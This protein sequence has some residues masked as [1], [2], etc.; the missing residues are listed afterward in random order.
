M[1]NYQASGILLNIPDTGYF[2]SFIKELRLKKLKIMVSFNLGILKIGFIALLVPLFLTCE[3]D[4]DDG[5]AEDPMETLGPLNATFEML[6]PNGTSYGTFGSFTEAT[7]STN[8]I[9]L[10][11]SDTS[12]LSWVEFNSLNITGTGQYTL[13][14]TPF[15]RARF[16][17]V[18]ST[19]VSPDFWIN[20]GNNP[21]QG[22]FLSITEYSEAGVSGTYEFVAWY[23]SP[24]LNR[25]VGWGLR[26]SFENVPFTE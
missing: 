21:T 24:T 15:A 2:M 13:L 19:A 16:E 18:Y 11:G 22:G 10:S 14:N 7:A 26:G 8:E 6:Y 5:I 20:Q 1:N 4:D 25:E 9:R 17:A 12:A 3:E 23:F